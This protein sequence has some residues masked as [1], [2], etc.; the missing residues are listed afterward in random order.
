MTSEAQQRLE[1]YLGR[2]RERLRGLHADDIRE[3]VEELRSHI[4][5]KAGAGGQL[6]AAG[7]AAALTALGSP[8]KLA[9]EYVTDSLLAQAEISRTPWDF[10]RTVPLGQ[11]QPSGIPCFDGIRRGEFPRGGFRA[12]CGAEAVP[13]ANGRTVADSGPCGRPSGFPSPRVRKSTDWWPRTAGLVDCADWASSG[14]PDGDHDLIA[15]QLV[16]A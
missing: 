13:P 9:G 1:E 4:L 12:V 15:L 10:R 11:S 7:V 5:D 6:T 3:I 8:E 16:F 14:L 2:L